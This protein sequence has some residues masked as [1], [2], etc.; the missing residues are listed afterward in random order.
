MTNAVLLGAAL[1]SIIS[2][3]VLLN[4]KITVI[5]ALQK[6]IIR[7]QIKAT[8]AIPAFP[9]AEDVAPH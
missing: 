8:Q 5:I 6:W 3:L 9:T 7:E 4:L 2:L 1:A